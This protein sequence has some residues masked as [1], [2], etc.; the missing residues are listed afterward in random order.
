MGELVDGAVYKAGAAC[1]AACGDPANL[2]SACAN[3][4]YMETLV[5]N[6]AKN[7]TGMTT[8]QMLQPW[9]EAFGEGRG[10]C[11]D[12]RRAEMQRLGAFKSDDD[13]LAEPHQPLTCQ[14]PELQIPIFHIIGN[15]TR[16]ATG[17]LVREDINDANGVF[18]YKGVWHVFHQCCQNHWDH[19]VSKDLMHWKRLPSP[20]RPGTEWY[21]SRGSFDG[22]A[23]ILPGKGPVILVDNIGPFNNTPDSSSRLGATDNPGCQGLS[24]PEDLTDPELTHW[25]KDARNPINI[26]NL[27]CGSRVK[28]SPGAFPGSIFQNGDHYNYLSF[29]YRFTSNDPTLHTWSRVEQPFLSHA[30][31]DQSK[32]HSCPPGSFQD[33]GGQWTLRVPATPSGTPP[34][35]G[36]PTHMVSCGQGNKFCLGYYHMDNE[37]WSNWTPQRRQPHR[38]GTNI[39]TKF[40]FDWD[41][42]GGDYN[43]NDSS[44]ALYKNCLSDGNCPC[45]KACLEDSRCSAWTVIDG[46]PSKWKPGPQ[47]SR[48]CLKHKGGAGPGQKYD[49]REVPGSGRVTGVKD[50]SACAGPAA[51]DD[52]AVAYT[53]A[54]GSDAGWL[55]AGYGSGGLGNGSS[56]DR[57]FN[58]GWA[59]RMPHG[60]LTV[61]RE[62]RYDPRTQALVANPVEELAG[63]RN[64]SLVFE[65][66]IGVE[67]GKPRLLEGT[68]GGMAIS[69]DIE[70]EWTLPPAAQASAVFGAEN[71]FVAQ[72]LL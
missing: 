60:G 16:N 71:A 10:A 6:P 54:V 43:Q 47:G 3:T 41:V 40:G 32:N 46:E 37:S 36:S 18:R 70:L 7:T 1:F 26:T 67:D 21:D 17:A 45:Q 35:L 38:P 31:C 63:L 14:P 50:P 59:T 15:I 53:E 25:R 34:P 30:F 58:I 64:A 5:G 12:V 20:V 24:W 27:D 72:F 48:C 55:T 39:C 42:P 68:E 57:L 29:G 51:D 49:P 66:N 33:D 11:P 61:M 4:C 62:I 9:E 69:A 8:A 44:R 13:S 23:A 52:V 2:T 56:N 65:V 28:N 22:S 19:V